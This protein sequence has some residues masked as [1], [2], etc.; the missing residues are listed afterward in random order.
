LIRNLQYNSSQQQIPVISFC[1]T[2]T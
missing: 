1:S 2:I